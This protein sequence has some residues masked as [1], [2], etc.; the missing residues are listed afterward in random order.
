[1]AGQNLHKVT[2]HNLYPALETSISMRFK[3]MKFQKF[4]DIFIRAPEFYIVTIFKHF[5]AQFLGNL[6]VAA[7]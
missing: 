7:Q 5:D 6:K 2:N 3:L 4:K 1:M